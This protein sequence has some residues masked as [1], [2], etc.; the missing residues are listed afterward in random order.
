M[1]NNR[2]MEHI[3]P[4]ESAIQIVGGLTALARLL[5]VA[6]PTVHEWKT[7]KRPVPVERCVAIERATESAVTRQDLRPD[8]W[9]DIWPE[10]AVTQLENPSIDKDLDHFMAQAAQAGLI[11]RRN[12]VRRAEDR[13][14]RDA[15]KAGQVV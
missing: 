6:P 13:A 5:G 9:Q 10:L 12:A 8:D 4:V 11:E 14:M 3:S 1:P 2:S 15:L 7:G